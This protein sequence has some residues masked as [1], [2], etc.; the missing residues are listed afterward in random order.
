MDDLVIRGATVIDGSG[1]AGRMTDVAVRDGRISAIGPRR[2]DSARREI[3]ATGR[4]LAP[5]FIDIHTHSDFTLTLNPMAEAKIRQGVTTEVVGNCGFSVAPALPGKAEL[6]AHYLSASAPWLPFSETDFAGYMAAWP[7]I[8]VN[9]VMQV[10]HNTLRLMAMGMDNR[11]PDD[12]ELKHMQEMLDEALTAGALG[13]STGLFTPPGLHAEPEEIRALGRVLKQHGA[14]YSSHIRDESHNVFEAVA[15]AI[16]VGESCG[17]HVQIAH[18][19]LSGIDSWG[20][21]DRLLGTIEA[22]RARGVEVHCDQYPYDTGS[23]PLRFLLPPWIHEGGMEA[24]LERLAEPYTRAR[25]KQKLVEV[26]FTNFGRLRSWDDIRIANSPTA[27]AGKTIETLARERGQDPLDVACDIIIAD[28][29]ATRILVRSMSEEDVQRIVTDP[30][31]MVGSDGPCVAPYGITGQGKPHPRLYGTFPRVLGHYARDLGLLG[32]PQ[33]V[34][35]MTGGAAMALGLADRG[36]IAVGNAADLVIFDPEEIIDSATFDDP[37]QYP[38]G[39]DTVLVN[40]VTVIDG[41]EHTGALPGRLLR[42]RGTVCA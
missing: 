40:G 17:I 3:D 16:D 36:T 39:I 24:M 35:K 6:L 20:G 29:G 21:A 30:M 22:A 33:A 7:E 1:T 27:T 8:A 12:S 37:H 23:N 4:V 26:G 11:P 18:L 42:R 25:I 31:V 41:G 34:F 28:R 5:G 32:L 19:K 2:S 14:R 15:E 9:T 38:V 13:M 10:G